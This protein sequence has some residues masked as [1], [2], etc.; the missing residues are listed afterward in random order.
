MSRD[1]H[2]ILIRPLLTEK[3]TQLKEQQNK[4]CFLVNPRSNKI[5]IK[6]AA[7]EVLKVK[8]DS[9][10]IIN[11]KG[12]RKRLGRYEGKRSDLKKAI[13]TIKKGEKL[14]LFEGV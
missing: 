1:A 13:L 5:E 11:T 9:V 14:E 6:R 10:N 3:M 7:E 2:E 8:I 4:I 12:K